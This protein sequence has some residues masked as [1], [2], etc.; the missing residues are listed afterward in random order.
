MPTNLVPIHAPWFGIGSIHFDP[1]TGTLYQQTAVQ[2]VPTFGVVSVGGDG[3]V[4]AADITDA[5]ATGIAAM[6]AVDS[7]ALRLA[8]EI[9]AGVAP[10]ADDSLY[11]VSSAWAKR[12][13][14]QARVHIGL[15]IGG[16]PI[17]DSAPADGTIVLVAYM[18]FACTFNALKNADMA[19]GSTHVAVAING[20]PIT[21]LS[22]VTVTTSGA[23]TN[24][25]AANTAAIGDLVTITYASSSTP[26]GFSAVLTY[27]R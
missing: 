22:D 11:G 18:P 21:G 14:A 4:A 13:P 12:T 8:A 10:S 26:V 25:T 19:S 9:A 20:T 16:I 17:Y 1:V 5:G 3:D 6:R 7:A 15:S 27:T 2:P 23:S 24:A